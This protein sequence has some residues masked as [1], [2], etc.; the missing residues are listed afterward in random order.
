LDAT[1]HAAESAANHDIFVAGIFFGL[2]TGAAVEFVD[3]LWAAFR[4][5]KRKRS[6]I[7]IV[8]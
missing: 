3:R 4:D 1:N 5:K 8:L 6:N 2:A 7:G